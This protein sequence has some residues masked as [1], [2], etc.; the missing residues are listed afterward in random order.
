MARSTCGSYRVR[1]AT[2][3]IAGR[4]I[5]THVES[6]VNAGGMNKPCEPTANLTRIGSRYLVVVSG[7][8][9]VAGKK[10]LQ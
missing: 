7:D 10:E 4:T 3:S 9:V 1:A 6:H 2:Y 5:F 8:K